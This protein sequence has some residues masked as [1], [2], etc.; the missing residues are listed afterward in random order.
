M[1]TLL[2]N[3][4]RFR[5]LIAVAALVAFGIFIAPQTAVGQTQDKFYFWVARGGNSGADSFVIE[6]DA[7]KKTQIENFWAQGKLPNFKGHIAVGSVDYNRNYNAPGH[8]V[9]NWYVASVDEITELSHNDT[10]YWPPRDGTASDIA[11]NPQGWIQQYG[12]A[13]GLEA[14]V[15][16]RQIDPAARDAMANVSNRGMAGNG[17]RK[18]I[19]GLILTGGSPRNVVV[20]ALGPSLSS[21]GIQQAAGNPK[22]E[23]YQGSTKIA[24]NADWKNDVRASSLA[25]S[26]PSLAPSNDKEAALLLTLFPGTYTLQGSNEDG[27]EGIVLLEAYDVDS[28]TP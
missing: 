11:A 12:D 18:L 3:M 26:Y 28:A 27:S 1:K 23:V 6:V 20:R 25:Q 16:R 5:S 2:P 13:I 17:E 4:V 8:P 9:W 19:T 10:L 15:I 21:A 7:A 14:Y 24:S 22:I